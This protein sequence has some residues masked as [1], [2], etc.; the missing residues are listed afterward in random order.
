MS[1]ALRRSLSIALLTAIAAAAPQ[2][3]ASQGGEVNL[4]PHLAV[5][6]LKLLQSRGKRPIESIRGRILYDFSGSSCEGYALQFRQVSQIDTGEGKIMLSDLRAATWE[7]GAAKSFRFNSQNFV[8]E[9]LADTVDG[10]AE[11]RPAEVGVSLTKPKDK[12]FSLEGG[13]IFPTEHMR[14]IIEAAR[15]GKSVLELAVYDGSETGEKVYDTLTV[16]GRPIAPDG[17]KPAGNVDAALADLQRWPVSISYFERGKK[18][19][20]QI[21][22]YSI[23]FELYD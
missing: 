1:C 9:K 17:N 10:K 18:G 7:E 5:Y 12:T 3:V 20:E 15:A 8:D 13:L 4:V 6:E 11:R 22:V 16:I 14:Q 23:G 19:G 21:P 2:F